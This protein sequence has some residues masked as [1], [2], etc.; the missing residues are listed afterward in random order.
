MRSFRDSLCRAV[1]PG[2]RTRHHHRTTATERGARSARGVLVPTGGLTS[3]HPTAAVARRPISK[4]RATHRPARPLRAVG[5][6]TRAVLREREATTR[7]RL[8]SLRAPG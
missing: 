1:R 5:A 3:L 4:A 2:G 8:S 6:R 7:Y